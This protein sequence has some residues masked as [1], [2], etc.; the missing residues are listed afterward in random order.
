MAVDI[1]SENNSI[2]TNERED[3]EEEGHNQ[4]IQKP[5]DSDFKNSTFERKGEGFEQEGD[6]YFVP[7]Q[8]NPKD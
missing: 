5:M 3:E 2:A 4:M 1:E 8:Y 7:G 6:D